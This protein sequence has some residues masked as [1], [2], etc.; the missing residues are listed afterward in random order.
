MKPTK[1]ST[2]N[3]VSS[4]KNLTANFD[5]KLKE[6]ALKGYIKSYRIEGEDRVDFDSYLDNKKDTVIN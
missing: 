1:Y 3:K 2:T 5:I 6:T 4:L